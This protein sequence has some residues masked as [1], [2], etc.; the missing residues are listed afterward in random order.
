MSADG[1]ETCAGATAAAVLL[2]RKKVIL[3]LMPVFSG[4]ETPE[5]FR[6]FGTGV[7]E[8]LHLDAPSRRA[9]DG[10]RPGMAGD[11]ATTV[12]AVRCRTVNSKGC[13]TN[14]AVGT[15]LTD[16]PSTFKPRSANEIVPGASRLFKRQNDQEKAGSCRCRCSRGDHEA[17]D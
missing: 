16:H 10:D 11:S 14:T 17:L 5:I 6:G 3:Y 15:H 4:A 9:S 1:S 2:L 13:R 12:G 7:L 8:E